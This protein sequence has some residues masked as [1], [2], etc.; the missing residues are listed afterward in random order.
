MRGLYLGAALLTTLWCGPAFAVFIVSNSDCPSSTTIKERVSGLVENQGSDTARALIDV[1]KDVLRIELSSYGERPR[2]RTLPT[3]GSCTDQAESIAL[4][5]AAWLDT[6]PINE[7][8]APMKLPPVKPEQK[9]TLVAAPVTIPWLR[10]TWF[11]FG[12]QGGR[13]D[14]SS[15][16]GLTTEIAFSHLWNQLG[17]Q[18]NLS[19]SWPKEH[20]I[21]QG[22][23]QLYRPMLVFA[24]STQSVYGAWSFSPTLGPSLSLLIV[25]GKNYDKDRTSYAWMGG[26]NVG[27][28]LT[29]MVGKR[30]VWIGSSFI[31]WFGPPKIRSVILGTTRTDKVQ[32]LSYWEWKLALG[33]SLQLL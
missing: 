15:M 9:M 18:V 13:D 2:V 23:A 28:R 14:H 8:A 19:M 30:S 1:Q 29:R 11:G 20:A 22:K 21:G 33:M 3:E 7:L 16:V 4:V 26:A 32:A 25:K 5:I 6:F 31:L 12:I 10:Q 24:L 27:G 17:G